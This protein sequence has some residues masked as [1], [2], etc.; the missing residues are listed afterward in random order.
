LKHVGVNA[1]RQ[2]SVVLPAAFAGPQLV[3]YLRDTSTHDALVE[4]TAI[5]DP[6]KFADAFGAPVEV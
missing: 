5:V 1:A 2:L 3:A 4:L 6:A